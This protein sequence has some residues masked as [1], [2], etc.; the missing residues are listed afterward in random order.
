[1]RVVLDT[2]ILKLATS[3][4]K[5]TRRP[6]SSSLL[7]APFEAWVTPAVLE[8]YSDVLADHPEFVAEIVEQ[9]SADKRQT[10]GSGSEFG[11]VTPSC[12]FP[13]KNAR[14]AVSGCPPFSTL[15]EPGNFAR[16]SRAAGAF[17]T[18]SVQTQ[19]GPGAKS[20][21]LTRG[22]LRST[23]RWEQARRRSPAS[24]RRKYHTVED[25]PLPTVPC[26]ARTPDTEKRQATTIE[27]RC[28]AQ[29]DPAQHEDRGRGAYRPARCP[30]IPN[31]AAGRHA[32]RNIHA[33][34]AAGGL[35]VD[36]LWR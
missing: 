22:W 19:T 30:S 21:S 24:A 25:H 29:R 16:S 3:P 13:K 32:L 14:V 17:T 5:T 18:A 10:I 23:H 4:S 33:L 26:R 35:I 7:E 8:E 15:Y 34:L 6:S 31:R 36:A 11:A 2:C 20:A 1:M 9:V 27:T 28:R 12:E